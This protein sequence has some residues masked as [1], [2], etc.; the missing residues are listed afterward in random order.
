MVSHPIFDYVIIFLIVISS[1]TFAIDSPLSNPHSTFSKVI[2]YIDTVL[3]GIFIIEVLIK[4]VAFGILFN[5]PNS[6][7][8]SVWNLIDLFI[9]ITSVIKIY[10]CV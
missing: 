10:S 9:I 5:G 4:M 3:T 7:L 2:Y 1:I 6:Y 8:R